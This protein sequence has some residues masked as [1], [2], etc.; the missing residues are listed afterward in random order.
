MG[1]GEATLEEAWDG[2]ADDWIR[3]SRSPE[4]DHAFWWLNLPALL[5]ILP[6]A[7]SLT[8]DIAC[9]EGRLSRRL[10]QLGHNVVGVEA[11][12][13][14]ADAARSADPSI[15]VHIADAT[16]IPLDDGAA[17]L[18]VASLALMNMDDMA[19]VVH[20]VARVLRPGGHFCFSVL[21]PMN[22]WGD[23][24]DVGYFESTRYAEQLVHDG[25]SMTVNEIHRPLG[26]YL[27]GLEDAGFLVEKFREP[28][29]DDGYV[30]DRPEVARWREKPAFLHVRA[31][32]PLPTP[33]ATGTS[34]GPHKVQ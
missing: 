12:T 15:A 30:A 18:V 5:E 25:A 2:S 21:H 6:P 1:E 14:L 31:L 29:P 9:G 27:G 7:G 11:S 34:W 32:K 8:V 19:G 3:W 26:D 24:G 17:D 23:A 20:E 10:R 16:A 4:L 28:V 22:S 13:V 33:G